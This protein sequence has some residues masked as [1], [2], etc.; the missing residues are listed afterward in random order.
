MQM[1]KRSARHGF[2]IFRLYAQH[3]CHFFCLSLYFIRNISLEESE[4]KTKLRQIVLNSIYTQVFA[5]QDI[6][7]ISGSLLIASLA[8]NT[9]TTKPLNSLGMGR[10]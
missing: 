4:K 5:S 2:D 9:V 3:I 8:D 10:R 1:D 7:T 6:L